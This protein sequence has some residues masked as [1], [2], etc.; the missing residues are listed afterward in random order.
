MRSILGK[1]FQP[2]GE[3]PLLLPAC[4]HD[5]VLFAKNYA[6][7]RKDIPNQLP[8]ALAEKALFGV[9]TYLWECRVCSEVRKEETL[10][11]DENQ[12]T[13]LLE[14]VEKFGMQYVEEG[15]KVFAIARVPEN[16]AKLPVR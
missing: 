4:T 9:T 3:E 16:E 15:G 5:W 11:S 6:P 7:A 10:G 1:L 14:K 13:Q 12:L 8:E 2:I